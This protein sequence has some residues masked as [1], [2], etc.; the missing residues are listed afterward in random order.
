MKK[1]FL[2]FM[3]S[4]SLES[5][6]QVKHYFFIG[7]DRDLL[8]D[9]NIWASPVF[10]G[11]QIAY[12][13]NQLEYQKDSFDFGM[14]DEDFALL[15]KH[16][17]KLFIQI[18]DVSFSMK[19]NHAPEYLLSDPVYH[20]GANKQ[21][22]FKDD[23]ETEYRELG[24]VIRRWD[25]EVQKRLHKLY[26]A[27]GKQFDG[28]IEGVNTEETAVDF[29]KGPL[30]PPGF[31]FQ[32]NKVATMENL[33]ALKK[34]FPKSVV[35]VYANF[36]PGGFLPYQDSSY[37]R[38]IYEF[39]VKNQIGVGGPDLLPY[40]PD[41][42]GNSYGFIRNSSQKVAAGVAVQDGTYEYINPRTKDKITA[43]EIYAFGKDYLGLKYIF[44]G[45]EEPFLH[46]EIIPFLKSLY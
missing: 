37:M 42:M 12:S 27:I 11:V 9:T 6:S 10:Y 7:M 36:M 34:A 20:G 45:S 46:T 1:I 22:K 28:K 14:I 13:W 16:G 5:Y 18:E 29:G 38:D 24:W 41:Q 43:A 35:L 31:N 39:A 40:K 32:R 26:Q 4:V 17:K 8:K 3:L 15:K 19:Y 25:P 33:A 44:W 23:N 2:L 30:H 21:Y